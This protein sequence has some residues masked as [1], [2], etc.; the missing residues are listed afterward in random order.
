M[1]LAL[2][3]LWLMADQPWYLKLGGWVLLT[4]LADECGGWFGYTVA[5]LG[6]APFFAGLLGYGALAPVQWA[7]LYPLVLTGLLSALLV[8]HAGGPLLLP[9]ALALLVAP[10]LVARVLGPQL[11][12]GITLPGIP[13]F[14]TY[15]LWPG[16]IG[17]A[18]SLG[19][20]ILRR[21][22]R[23]RPLAR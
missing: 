22:A 18:V 3:F 19:A 5:V 6:A 17:A 8:K 21:A 2:A 9:V 23:P 13:K 4:W 12:A 7:V 20:A 15:T 10:I 14:L 16:V 1:L 11:D